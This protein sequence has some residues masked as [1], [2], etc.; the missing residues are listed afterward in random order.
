MSFSRTPG[1]AGPYCETG[2]HTR[3]ILFELGYDAARIDQLCDAGVVTWPDKIVERT[4]L[5]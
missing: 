4:T 2:E 3:E 1:I 5:L